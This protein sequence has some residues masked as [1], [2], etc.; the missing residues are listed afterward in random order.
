MK[1]KKEI[2]EAYKQAKP[3]MGVFQ[4]RNTV[5]G[6][7]FIDNA[8][9]ISARQN[10]HRTE[11]KFGNHRNKQLQDDWKTYGADSFVFEVLAELDYKDEGALNYASELKELQQMVDEELNIDDSMKYNNRM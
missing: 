7:V 8:T 5:N 1:T 3:Q 9:D 11:L 6:K 4:I 2:K 10:R